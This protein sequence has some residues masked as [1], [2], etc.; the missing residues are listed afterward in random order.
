MWRKY[1]TDTGREKEFRIGEKK[2]QVVGEKS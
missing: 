2:K 1:S